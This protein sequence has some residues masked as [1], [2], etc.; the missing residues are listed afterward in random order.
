M[1]EGDI[2]FSRNLAEHICDI[3]GEVLSLVF[4]SSGDWAIGA[5][6]PDWD[7]CVLNLFP[8]QKNFSR[9]FFFNMGPPCAQQGQ[10][11][12]SPKSQQAL[13]GLVCWRRRKRQQMSFYA[14]WKCWKLTPRS[15]AWSVLS[16]LVR[17]YT[18]ACRGLT[19]V[20]RQSINDKLLRHGW[21]RLLHKL[22]GSLTLV[23]VHNNERCLV[24]SRVVEFD[25]DCDALN[26]TGYL[27]K[28]YHLQQGLIFYLFIISNIKTARRF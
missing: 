1:Q 10:R 6:C 20:Q 24:C 13:S 21:E 7:W 16:C 18:R 26:I 5:K 8:P 27:S 11:G 4:L 19:W 22:W 17:G 12:K 14:K 2:V 23:C 9:L 25:W 28:L 15:D 3:A